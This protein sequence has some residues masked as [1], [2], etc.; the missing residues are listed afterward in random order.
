MQLACMQSELL[1][2]RRTCPG[3]RPQKSAE[4]CSV[5]MPAGS[6]MSLIPTHRSCSGPGGALVDSR[7]GH[8]RRG[9]HLPL[10]WSVRGHRRRANPIRRVSRKSGAIQSTPRLEAERHVDCLEVAMQE[11]LANKFPSQPVPGVPSNLP[12]SSL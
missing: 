12:A 5:G 3:T 6:M 4:L 10:P 2:R 7:C 8:S 11:A 9:L 1:V